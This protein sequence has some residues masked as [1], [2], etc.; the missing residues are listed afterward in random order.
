L[1]DA[2]WPS[3][4]RGGPEPGDLLHLEGID[5]SF[6][7]TQAL[8]RASLSVR[9][10]E[11][12]GLLGQN[13]SGKSTLIKILAGY[14]SPSAGRL[15]FAG[16]EYPLPVDAATRRRM[17]LAFV[18]QD[19]GLLP[20]LSVLENFCAGEWAEGRAWSPIRWRRTRRAVVRALAERGVALDPDVLVRDL[21]PVQ[22]A[23]LAVI[24]ALHTM[25]RTAGSGGPGLLVLDEPTTFLAGADADHLYDLMRRV[26]A[27]GSS[28][29]FI[30]HDIEE[31]K[32]V[33]DRVTVLRDG[34]NVGTAPTAD[35]S[36]GQIIGMVVGTHVEVAPR[37]HEERLLAETPKGLA[38]SELVTRRLAGV[39]FDAPE[40]L[41]VG[42]TGLPGSGYEDVLYSLYGARAARSGTLELAG[43]SLELARMKP[44]DA[45]GAGI[46]FVPGDRLLEGC[47]PHL[48][49]AE[50][51]SLPALEACK[52]GPLFSN[53]RTK[54]LTARQIGAYGIVASSVDA[55]YATMS[56]GNQQKAILAKWLDLEP[57]VLLLNQ[58]TQGVD[59][60]AR[61]EIWR[62]L[63][64]AR[65]GRITICASLD[66]DELITLADVV[67][68]FRRGRISG[69]L[70]GTEMTREAITRCSVEEAA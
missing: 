60:G 27:D 70:E 23:V 45:R 66:H 32:L 6:G 57:A 65:E 42:L 40:G 53:K 24:R 30:S 34:A 43:R 26:A 2:A 63:R 41:I 49:I 3:E 29:L 8:R 47:V 21:S 62:L 54:A 59:V 36:V 16:E 20:G 35:V 12:H 14:H 55:P 33:T 11:I 56:G 10:G 50:N 64:E 48:T 51:N 4:G 13:G 67:L 19:L 68:V 52:R 58:P 69:R 5:M 17:R 9:V 46:A 39:S 28:V 7:A 15:W 18:H 38:V 25:R 22:R 1:T 37:A 61:A 31:V 44:A